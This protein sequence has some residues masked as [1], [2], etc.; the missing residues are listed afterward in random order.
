[1]SETFKAY[2]IDKTDE[3]RTVTLTDLTLDDLPDQPV[4]VKVAYSTVN[5]KDGLAFSDAV[6]IVRSYPMVPGI[7]IA[8]EVVES[9][10]DRFSPGDL[11]TLN[12]YGLSEDKWG[13][14]SQYARVP[15][16]PLIKIPA[17]IKP[18]TAAAIGT[19]G[20]TAMLSVLALEDQGVKPEDGEVL[21]T[22]AAGGVG[23]VAIAL[24][25]KLGYTVIA[26][27]G[28]ASEEDYLKGLGASAI[29]DRN[30]LSGEGRPLGKERWAAA[31]DSVGSK[32]LANVLSQIKYGGVVTACGLAQGADLPAT[33]MPFI[34]RGVTLCGIDSVMAP[35]SPRERAWSRLATD[36]ELD[37]L[38][39]MIEEIPLAGVEAKTAEI[40]KGAVRGRLVVDV[41]A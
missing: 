33:V 2:K 5:Y 39:A 34:L 32:T 10:D 11:V 22:G 18:R 36:L 13:G 29:I 25:S 12:G 28:R 38:E 1:M 7:D 37:K 6:P 30:E 26:S 35:R 15:A 24:L 21:V 19:A 3:A 4:L 9:A 17:P 20:Y 27:T 8:G 41:N 23:S 16:E 31:V 40:L 14:Y